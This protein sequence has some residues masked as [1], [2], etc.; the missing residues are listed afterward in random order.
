MVHRGELIV[1]ARGVFI[2]PELGQQLQSMP[3]GQI[4]IRAMAALAV[5]GRGT[6][7]SHGAAAEL[8]GLD[9]LSSGERLAISRPPAQGSRSDRK[10]GIAVHAAALPASHIGWRLGLPVTTVPRTVVDLA[11]ALEFR[12]GLVVADSALHQHL[13]SKSELRAVLADCRRWPGAVRAAEVI[14]FADGLAES[15]LESLGRAAFRDLGLPAPEL[16]VDIADDDGAFIGRVDFLWRQ[17]RTIAEVDGALKYDDRDR[18]RAELRRDKR[19]RG[20]RYEV[21][22]F[23]WREIMHG[24]STVGESMWA[25]FERGSQLATSGPAA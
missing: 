1:L 18:A 16:Q 25:A 19:L 14:E 20:A 15:V 22:H 9:Q 7:V 4:A 23:T 24:Q 12:D 17:F 21:E 2:S 13:T 10:P 11:R 5:L 6:V 3:A 8:H